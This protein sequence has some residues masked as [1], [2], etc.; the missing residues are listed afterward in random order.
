[1]E[2]QYAV[3]ILCLWRVNCIL[4]ASGDSYTA[5]K[6][7][8]NISG[9]G[10]RLEDGHMLPSKRSSKPAVRLPQILAVVAETPAYNPG[11]DSL[12]EREI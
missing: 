9:P 12:D 2:L 8:Q 7:L 1:M 4:T 11:S 5:H 6:V 3:R 10:L